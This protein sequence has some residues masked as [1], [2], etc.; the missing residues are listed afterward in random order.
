P[1]PLRCRQSLC[2]HRYDRKKQ[3]RLW[4]CHAD[5]AAPQSYAR[6]S[7]P[8]C[9]PSQTVPRS[10]TPVQ[11]LRAHVSCADTGLRLAISHGGLPIPNPPRPRPRKLSTE[12]HR[13]EDSYIK[14]DSTS[15]TFSCFS[16]YFEDENEG[17]ED[18]QQQQF[19]IHSSPFTLLVQHG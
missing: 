15:D 8:F 12:E 16:L 10:R 19:S 4:P 2:L 14:A 6:Q 18:Y 1:L 13:F 5:E 9:R 3:G 7:R 17:E 11:I